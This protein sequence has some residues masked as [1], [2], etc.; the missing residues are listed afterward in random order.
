ML[1]GSKCKSFLTKRILQFLKMENK[2]SPSYHHHL[3]NEHLQLLSLKEQS[4]FNIVLNF[5]WKK[6]ATVWLTGGGENEILDQPFPEPFTRP[7]RLALIANIWMG[8]QSERKK[9]T[10]LHHNYHDVHVVRTLA[11]RFIQFLYVDALSSHAWTQQREREREGIL[12]ANSSHHP[13][14]L[15]DPSSEVECRCLGK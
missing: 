1:F 9:W 10:L 12:K 14:I 8:L 6:R 3:R 7:K 2:N 4:R 11:V 15:C 13:C 5:H